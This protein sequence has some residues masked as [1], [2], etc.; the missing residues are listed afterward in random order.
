LSAIRSRNISK[1][2]TDLTHQHEVDEILS[3]NKRKRVIRRL[4]FFLVITL[5]V[6][7]SMTS[8]LISQSS[9]LE[10]KE[11]EK[12]KLEQELAELKKQQVILDEE[13][14]KLNDD[15]YIAKLARSEF[16]LSKEDEIIFTIPT[17]EK[18]KTSKQLTY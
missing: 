6:G 15:E 8:S 11:A 2:E 12:A 16:F 17:E 3:S 5:I 10:K 18:G 14:I 7:Y 13:I 9:V 4:S 1:I